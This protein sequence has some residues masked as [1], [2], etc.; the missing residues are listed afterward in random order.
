[1]NFFELLEIY[2]YKIL[3]FFKKSSFKNMT[4]YILSFVLFACIPEKDFSLNQEKKHLKI[5]V[6]DNDMNVL[7]KKV[8]SSENVISKTKSF[9]IECNPLNHD[10][11]NY[12]KFEE[13][14]SNI[15]SENE[16]HYN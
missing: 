15:Y 8:D 5:F 1:M 3:S 11:L 12:P 6:H 13:F 4:K 14:M 2:N 16:E 7:I 9:Y 10:Y